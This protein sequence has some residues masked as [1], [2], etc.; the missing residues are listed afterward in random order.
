MKSNTFT[1]IGPRRIFTPQAIIDSGQGKQT[2]NVRLGRSGQ[3][4]WLQVD[5]MPNVT[6]IS[7]GWLSQLNTRPIIYVGEIVI[8]QC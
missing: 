7:P 1:L 2:H 8:L 6:G 5:S 4:G 3:I